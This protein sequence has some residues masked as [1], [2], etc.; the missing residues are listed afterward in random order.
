MQQAAL[1]RFISHKKIKSTC[2]SRFYGHGESLHWE[3]EGKKNQDCKQINN[4][5]CLE[6]KGS[7]LGLTVSRYAGLRL[8]APDLW[9]WFIACHVALPDDL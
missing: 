3:M 2:E 1:N 5:L 6:E 7:G 4:L 8:P 9:A